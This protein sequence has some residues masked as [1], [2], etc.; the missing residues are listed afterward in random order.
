[1]NFISMITSIRRYTLYALCILALNA[2]DSI[3][4]MPKEDCEIKNLVKFRYDMNLKF[5]N[6]F[7]NEIHAVTL[8]AFNKDSIFLFK[9]EDEGEQLK[10]DDYTLELPVSMDSL[11]LITW[12]EG[13][14]HHDTDNYCS[15]ICPELT[16]G[17]STISDLLWKLNCE[18]IND[19]PTMNKQLTPMFH[20]SSMN[21][22]SKSN[23]TTTISLTKNTNNLKIVL[24]QQSE[25]PLD[26]D[27]FNFSIDMVNCAL[28]YDNRLLNVDTIR[29][30]PWKKTSTTAE[31]NDNNTT[32]NVAI[33]DF[34]LGRL[35]VG[36][37]PRLILRNP[38]NKIILSI[39]I[40]DYALLVKGNYNVEMS[41]Q[42]YLDRQDEYNMT[43]FIDK[44]NEWIASS[45]IINGWTVV[46]NESEIN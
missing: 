1:M 44:D 21:N 34:S 30:T 29:F 41:D 17:I 25:N 8:Y 45:I 46:L 9:I 18:Y 14:G 37:S 35:V 19:I 7:A 16:P 33:A 11:L 4:G 20:G 31:I 10:K 32:V 5:A 15:C 43:F 36:Q 23:T 38:E 6:A 13:E 3:L 42:E 2:C 22:K 12:C 27:K 26:I 39:P 40:I 28:G 24:Q